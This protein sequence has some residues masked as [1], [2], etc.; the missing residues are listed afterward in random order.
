MNGSSVAFV[1]LMKV[2]VT[3]ICVSIRS[4]CTAGGGGRASSLR[5]TVWDRSAEP[6]RAPA[7][8]IVIHD[9]IPASITSDW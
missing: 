1:L 4:S 9:S 3:L 5:R 2:T 8:V 7:S 6:V